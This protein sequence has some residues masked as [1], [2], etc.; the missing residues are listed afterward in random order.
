MDKV[1]EMKDAMK[2]I[3]DGDTVM[4]SGFGNIGA[5]CNLI[6]AMSE[7]EL[8]DIDLICDNLGETVRGFDQCAERLLQQ[9]GMIKKATCDFI[10]P[11]PRAGRRIVDGEL[12]VTFVPFGTLAER[13]RCG[14]YG[15]GGF[16][17]KTGVGTL[18]EEGKETKVI[19]GEKYILELPLRAD[20]SL[21]KAWKA[22]RMGNALFKYTGE[23]MNTIMA[24]AG[25]I[26][27]LEAE[28]IVEVG[29]IDPGDVRLP[30]PFIDHIVHCPKEV[31]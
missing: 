20:V 29:E 26:A 1:I 28:E 23:N 31:L 25:D 5:P 11:N 14:A 2:L 21:V 18:V 4:I 16:Y 17:T 15:I 22:D 3:H 19:N 6:M 27:I 7:T 13:I 10:G 24:A 9:K 8:R 12:A 30:G